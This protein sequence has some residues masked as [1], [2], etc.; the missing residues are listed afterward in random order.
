[1]LPVITFFVFWI[2]LE[3]YVFFALRRT[4]TSSKTRIAALIWWGFGLA[5]VAAS[6]IG[7]LAV[8]GPLVHAS[9]WQN[10]LIGLMF[11]F[12]ITKFIYAIAYGI[13]DGFRLLT[14]WRRWRASSP[15]AQAVPGTTSPDSRRR[16]VGQ[17]AMGIAAFPFAAFLHGVV[18]GRYQFELRRVQLV[19]PDLPPAFDG[20]TIIQLSDF[21]A[22]SF[23][24]PVAVAK[25]LDL[26]NQENPDLV[27][28]SGDLVNDRAEEI[29][30]YKEMFGRL[31]GR[32]GQYA[33]L[34]NHDYGGYTNE[35]KGDNKVKNLNRLKEHH[36]DMGFTMLNNAHVRLE[37][38]GQSIVLAGV[39]NWGHRPFPQKGDLDQALAGTNQEDFVVLL[40]HDPT[41]WDEKVRPNDRRV[42]LTLS[43]HTHGAQ[44]GVEAPPFI[45]WSP[46]SFVYPRWAG[47]YTEGKENLYVNRG[48]GYIGF[49]GRVGIWP[50]VTRIELVRGEPS[51]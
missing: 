2:A 32:M 10:G 35:T 24:D 15:P 40:S 20:L 13:G 41:H 36:A 39:E 25:G 29:E 8:G 7:A 47:L 11:T 9:P 28:F 6:I 38:D 34:G 49:P 19:F 51:A 45:R 50:E 18:R 1:M 31:R 17:L 21:H 12:L 43:G 23:D 30:P 16:F 22:G 42:D 37:R 5:A 46:S 44:M 48:F 33:S 4:L 26:V 3:A 27:L 14:R